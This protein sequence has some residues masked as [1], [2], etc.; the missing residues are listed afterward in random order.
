[1]RQARSSCQKSCKVLILEIYMN[2]VGLTSP[3]T[4]CELPLV[5]YAWT[6]QTSLVKVTSVYRCFAKFQASWKGGRED[7]VPHQVNSQSGTSNGRR[8]TLNPDS[9]Q[10]GELTGAESLITS[11]SNVDEIR[12]STSHRID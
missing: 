1:M 10:Q 4:S 6:Q 12:I 2:Y 11:N 3:P 9:V 5:T 7:G 8:D